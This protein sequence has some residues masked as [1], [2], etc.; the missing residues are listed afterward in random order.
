ML[1]HRRV[2]WECLPALLDAARLLWSSDTHR[3]STRDP[4]FMPLAT[5][6]G[7]RSARQCLE[8]RDFPRM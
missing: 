5:F 8:F 4:H 2:G 7:S 3:S 6:A 1:R